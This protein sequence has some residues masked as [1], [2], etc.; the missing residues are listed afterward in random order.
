MDGRIVLLGIPGSPVAEAIAAQL[1]GMGREGVVR[2]LLAPLAGRPVTVADGRVTWEGVEL[3][4]AAALFV[5]APVFPWPQPWRLA[6]LAPGGRPS[7]ELVAAE[8]EGRSLLAS[9]LLAAAAAVP[10]VVPPGTAHEAVVPALPLVSAAR[11]G[12]PVAPWTLEPRP[13]EP[14]PGILVADAAGRDLVHV[15]ARPPDPGEPALLVRAG[16]ETVTLLVAG[17]TVLAACRTREPVLPPDPREA[18]AM[19]PDALPAAVRELATAAAGRLPLAAVTLTTG[20]GPRV[21]FVEAA[22]DLAAWHT[23]RGGA[24][25]SG[26]ARL[27]ASLAEHHEED[28]R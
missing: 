18:S 26:V 12:L 9:A 21:A 11:A 25:A 14:P 3:T 19:E 27:L 16:G 23:A 4:A 7:R 6:E 2:D 24:I 20:G 17:H 10:A 13:A 22:P 15:P 1:A 8:R 28:R 5:E